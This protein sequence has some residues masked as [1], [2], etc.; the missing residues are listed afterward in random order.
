TSLN[1]KPYEW[2]FPKQGGLAHF[3]L[4][5]LLP[6]ALQYPHILQ[7][8]PSNPGLY[9]VKPENGFVTPNGTVQVEVTRSVGPAGKNDEL[10]VQWAEVEANVTDAR[11]IS[12]SPVLAEVGLLLKTA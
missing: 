7:I 8:N 2:T 5:S 1:I 4:T 6:Y 12:N 10:V 9:K 11:T 3:S